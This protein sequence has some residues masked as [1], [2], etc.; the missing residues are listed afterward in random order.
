MTIG[1][2]ETSDVT[3]HDPL[4]SRNH[5]L[6][7]IG[8]I[9]T[10]EDLESSNGTVVGSRRIA[11]RQPCEVRLGE[12][13]L[14]GRSALVLGGRTVTSPELKASADSDGGVHTP[15]GIVLRDPVV[16]ERAQLLSRSADSTLTVLLLGETGVGKEVFADLL[17][18]WSPR[19]AAPLVRINCAAIPD[20]LIESELFGYERGAFSGATHSKPGLLEIAHGGTAFLDE[21]GDLPA[22]A[23]A[24]LSG[25]IESR[26]VLR[27]GSLKPRIVDV[28]FVA[29]TN[30]DLEADVADGRFREDLYF[31]L[32]GVS[33]VIPP[34]RER[35]SDIAPLVSSFLERS[36]AL[37]GRGATSVSREA[38]QALENHHWPGNIREL[39]Q[40]IERAL[41]LCTGD[42]I[43]V[44]HLHLQRRSPL[45]ALQ[46]VVSASPA[47]DPPT[48]GPAPNT[49]SSEYQRVMAALSQCAGNQTRAAKL[50]GVSRRTFVTKLERYGVARPRKPARQ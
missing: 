8:D 16:I 43:R 46:P 6:L 5:A 27:L 14:I 1:R 37:T 3:I 21:V 45:L 9:V 32:N 17:H 29:A 12:P 18:Q 38:S 41:L 22:V 47:S 25:V 15:S 48:E 7:R 30:R 20:N 28:R 19:H 11:P 49:A 23:Q 36:R 34:L 39:R 10:I 31:R 4:A 40:V 42:E 50:L 33:I 13:V 24:R 35:I 44:E 2:S 26:E